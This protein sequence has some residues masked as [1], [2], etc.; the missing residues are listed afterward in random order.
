MLRREVKISKRVKQ[1][2][3]RV[4]K[5]IRATEV[6][7][8][9]S[10]GE[11]VG[12]LPIAEAL[13]IAQS[14]A[15]DLV[16]VSPDARPPVCKIMDHG[17]YKYELTKKKQEAKRKQKSVQ[18]KEIKVRPKT[19]DHDL[20]TKVRHVDKFISNGDKVKI[21]LV[22]RGRE[23]MLR[24]QANIILEKVVEMTKDFAQVE[25]LPKFEGRVITMLLGPK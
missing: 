11:Q 5:G 15:L 4:N 12:V 24:E 23:F 16:E 14:D 18:I 7:V 9:G 21:T 25:Q 17:K 3:T 22:F 13:R 20:E 6:R 19:G 10:D 8:I 1:D 2:Q